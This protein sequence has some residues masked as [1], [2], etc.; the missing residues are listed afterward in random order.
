[1]RPSPKREKRVKAKDV[2]WCV[3]SKRLGTTVLG[4]GLGLGRMP[5]RGS[6]ALTSVASELGRS[7]P[8]GS[9]VG[10]VNGSVGSVNG[11]ADGNVGSPYRKSPPTALGES[12]FTEIRTRRPFC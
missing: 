7:S 3:A 10:S 4:K 9:V 2:A 1:M 6:S 5:K 12:N 11:S 8:D